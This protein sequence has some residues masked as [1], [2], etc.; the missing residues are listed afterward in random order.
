M[1]C[2]ILGFYPPHALVELLV[3]VGALAIVV[4]MLVFAAAFAGGGPR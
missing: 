4:I 2:E 1:T 3:L